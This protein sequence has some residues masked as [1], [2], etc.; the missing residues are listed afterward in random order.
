MESACVIWLTGISGAG[1]TTLARLLY[2]EL[3][4]RSIPCEMI[5]GE[6]VRVFFGNDL[7]FSKEDRI[8]NLKRIVYGAKL[9]SIHGVITIVAAISPS[10]EGRNF[11]RKHLSKYIQ[12]YVSVP[13]PTAIERDTKGHYKKFKEENLRHLIGMDDS[14]DVPRSPDLILHTDE[15]TIDQSFT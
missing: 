15:E 10:Y 6:D 5:D 13:L 7:K 2:K 11:I 14:Y 12:I 4:K 1:K 3:L 9:L 8:T